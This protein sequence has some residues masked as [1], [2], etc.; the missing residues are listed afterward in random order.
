MS[1]S[2]GTRLSYKGNLLHR[3]IRGFMIQGGD[4]TAGN[5]SGGASIYG[6]KFAD[7]GFTLKHDKPFVLS[8]ANGGPNTNSSQFFITFAPAPHLDSKHV[9]FGQVVVGRD[10][11]R[12]FARL[13]VNISRFEQSSKK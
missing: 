12:L 2:D 3:I 9:V 7:E 11:V 8:M 5:G 1:K 13:I 4:I 6:A 10:V